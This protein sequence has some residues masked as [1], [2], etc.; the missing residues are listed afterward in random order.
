[1]G[2]PSNVHDM[3]S[4]LEDKQM[5]WRLAVKRADVQVD[6]LQLMVSESDVLADVGVESGGDDLDSLVVGVQLVGV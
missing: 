4:A 3:I 1:M 5:H 2:G 6:L